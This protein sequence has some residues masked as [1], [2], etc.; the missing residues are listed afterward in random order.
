MATQ[1]TISKGLSGLPGKAATSQHISRQ[2][3]P[4]TGAPRLVDMGYGA[5][6]NLYLQ[7]QI[8]EPRS[9]RTPGVTGQAGHRVG[10]RGEINKT[11]P[12]WTSRATVMKQAKGLLGDSVCHSSGF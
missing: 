7:K 9:P 3:T 2:L 4:P 8:C 1:G 6:L 5:T 11:V 10:V 12:R